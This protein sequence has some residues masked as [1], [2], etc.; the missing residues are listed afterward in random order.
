MMHLWLMVLLCS[1]ALAWT[2]PHLSD[3]GLMGE[4]VVED[5]VEDVVDDDVAEEAPAPA[6]TP[7]T[8]V[9]VPATPQAEGLT[10]PARHY[11]PGMPL[12]GLKATLLLAVLALLLLSGELSLRLVSR[13][14][15]PQGLLP[16]AAETTRVVLRV[17]LVAVVLGLGASLLPGYLAPAL[18]IFLVALAVALGWSSRDLLPDLVAGLVIVAERRIRPGY[19]L[20]VG[21]KVGVV[22]SVGLR[23]T[24]LRDG[25]G[26]RLALPNRSLVSGAVAADDQR[27]PLIEA[28]VHVMPGT[29][30]GTTRTILAE[31]ALLSPWVAPEG[32]ITALPSRDPGQW[33]VR[34]RL[35]E[36][37]FAERFEAAL[38]EEVDCALRTGLLTPPT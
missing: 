16:R 2:P 19:R 8:M 35:L 5:V 14:L 26:R 7:V 11:L 3:T 15:A 9:V 29:D 32:E 25:A 27:W 23:A 34:A 31:A 22:E 36:A 21:D 4:E 6:L 30:P 17:L 38:Q 18:P 1:P 13:R 10:E 24:W 28:R 20:T 12:R 33:R 37:R